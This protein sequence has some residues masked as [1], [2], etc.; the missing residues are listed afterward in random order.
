MKSHAGDS[1]RMLDNVDR[2]ASPNECRTP[3]FTTRCQKEPARRSVRDFA[4]IP[5]T[6]APEG[7]RSASWARSM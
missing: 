7:S 4:A 3:R 1:E 2:A 5:V 6:D